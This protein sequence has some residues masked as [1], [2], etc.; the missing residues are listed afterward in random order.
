MRR[1]AD[2]RLVAG[3]PVGD[4]VQERADY[5]AEDSC[6]GGDLHT[7]LIDSCGAPLESPCS[8]REGYQ[9][10]VEQPLPVLT[11]VHVRV[12]RPSELRLIVNSS[13]VC[14]ATAVTLN[15][16]AVTVGSPER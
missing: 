3:Q 1:R 9:L 5:R 16:Y 7:R 10:P 8:P 2:E 14:A 4:H 15:V 13:S 12:M 11:G 6:E